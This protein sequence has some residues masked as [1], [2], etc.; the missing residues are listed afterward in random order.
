MKNPSPKA[1]AERQLEIDRRRTRRFPDLQGRKWSRMSRSPLS[2]LRGAAPLYYEILKANPDLAGG[3]THTGWIVGDAHLENFGAYQ[4]VERGAAKKSALFDL[5]DF[6]D[7]VVAPW[8]WDVLR[9]ATSLLL[10]GRELGVSGMAAIDLCALFLEGY[11]AAACSGA[12]RPAPPRPI[13]M[14]IDRAK[15]RTKKE[16]LDARTSLVG[17][18]RRFA[19][20]ERY[21]DLPADVLDALPPAMQR[22]GE[23]LQ[24]AERPAPEQLEV[25]DAAHRIAGTGSLGALRIAVLTTGKGAPDGF[26]LFDLKEQVPPAASVV[27][28]KLGRQVRRSEEAIRACVEAP[29]RMLGTA[30]LGRAAMLVRRLTPQEDK[31]DLDALSQA[32]LDPLARYLGA[33]LGGAH[34][35]GA[36]G[37]HTTRWSRADRAAL[38]E[39]ATTMAGLHEAIYLEFCLRWRHTSFPA[40]RNVG[41]T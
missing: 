4:A 22:F 8:R 36:R 37:G 28:P 27:L 7:A 29:P 16:L 21:R 25:V 23:R 15:L 6:D 18:K 26:W 30:A 2:F 14:L 32:D 3:P 12:A 20:G 34:A 9:L 1:W 10:A 19:R 35:R 33:L 39:R 13:T 11:V 5:N 38:L 17:R 41:A 40:S 31:L 24:A